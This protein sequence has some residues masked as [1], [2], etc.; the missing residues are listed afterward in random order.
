MKASGS[1]PRALT[2]L[3]AVA[4]AFGGRL[5]GG[6]SRGVLECRGSEASRALLSGASCAAGSVRTARRDGRVS[7]RSEACDVT[8]RLA[9]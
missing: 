5:K 4:P 3:D 8:L 9:T 6:K 1:R 7:G 2:W